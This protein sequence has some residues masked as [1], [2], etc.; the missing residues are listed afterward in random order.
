MPREVIHWSV[1]E[2]VQERLGRESKVVALLA[3]ES[4][5]AYLG[6]AGVILFWV[7]LLHPAI[8]FLYLLEWPYPLYAIE[9]VD[10]LY[11]PLH[12]TTLIKLVELTCYVGDV[13]PDIFKPLQADGTD[14]GT[15][16]AL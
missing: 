14:A 7:K 2:R 9:Q 16:G 10:L 5:A 12:R 13:W 11:V 8:F 15:R 3:S 4:P 1:L 6:G